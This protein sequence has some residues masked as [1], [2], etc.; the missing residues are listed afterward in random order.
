MKKVGVPVTPRRSAGSTSSAIRAALSRLR[1]CSTESLAVEPEVA[2]VADQVARLEGVLVPQ[3]QVV[4]LPE[5]VLV[6]GG[7][8]GFGGELGVRVD[9]VQR[10]VAPH[11]PDVAVASEH[12][13]QD[14][15]GLAAVGALEVAVL[16]DG[17][18]CPGGAAD[19]VA[20]RVNGLAEVGDDLSGAEQGA[21]PQPGWQEADGA[22]DE[23]GD[24]RRG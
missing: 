19:A 20:G 2:G 12:V 13:P 4:H 1:R 24:R 14:G 6:S 23:P 3:E 11:V 9:V 10:E 7:F 15:L 8:R 16:H 21:D 22:E 18:R 5:R 17:D